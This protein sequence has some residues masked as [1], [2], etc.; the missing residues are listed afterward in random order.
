MLVD[1]NGAVIGGY[2]DRGRVDTQS[3]Q[4]GMDQVCGGYGVGI[5][6]FTD[7]V[8]FAE[9]ESFGET[10]TAEHHAVD[11]RPVISTAACI[12]FGS[13]TELAHGDNKCFVQKS[14]FLEIIDQGGGGL[15]ECGDES[16]T[17]FCARVAIAEGDGEVFMGIPSGLDNGDKSHVV[18]DQSSCQ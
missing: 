15:V 2:E 1:W 4:K 14:S 11:S 7:V 10:A 3:D 17:D 13:A 12:E 9:D 16:H 6:L 8:A 5:G 18:F